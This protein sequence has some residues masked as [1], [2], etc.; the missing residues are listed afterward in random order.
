MG[1]YYAVKVGRVPGIYNTWSECEKQV[2]GF[3]GATYKSF[4]TE[5]EARKYVNIKEKISI[6]TSITPNIEEFWEDFTIKSDELKLDNQS[7]GQINNLKDKEA[8]IYV[9]GSYRNND[10]S[11]SYGYIIIDK[12]KN[13]KTGSNRIKSNEFSKQRNVAGEVTGSVQAIKE[14]INLGYKSV[15][16]CHDYEGIAKWA[17]GEWKANNKY[18]KA[19]NQFFR[20]ASKVI[21][22]KFI[23]VPAHSGVYLNEL[24]DNL[25]KEAKF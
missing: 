20:E 8:L 12:S 23:K 13:F 18:T 25:A 17:T 22:I 9:D 14:A 15:V 1:K 3:S 5:E 10:K 2:K 24:V 16:I 4:T 21:D 6:D 7:L 11:Y 19:Y